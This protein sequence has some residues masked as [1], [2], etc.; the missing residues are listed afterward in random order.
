[1]SRAVLIGPGRYRRAIGSLTSWGLLA[2]VVVETFADLRHGPTSPPWIVS[3]Y[4]VVDALVILV[5][6]PALWLR[7]H[8]F[9]RAGRWILGGALGLMVWAIVSA[10]VCPLPDLGLEPVGR[11]LLVMAPVTAV[12]TLLAGL[13]VAAGLTASSSRRVVIERLW[14]PAAAMTCASYLQW[15]RAMRVHGSTRLATGM[16]GSAVLHVAL[17]LACGVLVAAAVAGYRRVAS[18]ILAAGAIVAIILTG[19]RSGLACAT[20]FVLGCAIGSVVWRRSRVVSWA[21][22]RRMVWGGLTALAVVVVGMV[23]LVPGLRRMLNPSDPMRSR[24]LRTGIEVW[25]SDLNHVFFG[26]GSGRLWPWYLYDSHARREPWRGLMTTQWGPT[27]SSAHSTV[28]AVLVE[29]GLLGLVLLL[30]VLLVPVVELVRRLLDGTCPPAEV[31]L[32]WAV[33]AT[34]PAFLLDTYLV[35]NFGVSM[36]WWV[37]VL[38]TVAWADQ[39]P[40]STSRQN[41]G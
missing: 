11:P 14:W 13:S 23:I 24:T 4:L 25:S 3:S 12:A 28:L 15:P 21:G 41:S 7:R 38:S 26:L 22:H 1:M 6:G 40:P 19:S 20:L 5:C 39:R 16:G 36:W 34:L 33:V 29:L 32:R 9:G 8:D 18:G 2:L 17:L 27:L 10:S 37:V 30:P 31:V 35:K